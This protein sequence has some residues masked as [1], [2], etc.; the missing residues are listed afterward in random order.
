MSGHDVGLADAVP[1]ERSIEDGLHEVAI[2]QVIGPLAL[3]L[4]TRGN[5][6][7]AQSLFSVTELLQPGIAH[8]QIPGDQGHLD[9]DLPIPI[10]FR[11][12]ALDLHG[13]VVFAFRAILFHPSQRPLE[14]L[15]IVDTPLHAAY[16]LGHVD[17][18]NTHA[19]VRLKHSLVHDGASDPHGHTAHGQVGFA[20]HS[21]HRQAGFGKLQQ[22][23][24]NIPRDGRIAR[25]LDIPAVDAESR[26][27]LLGV[28]GHHSRQIDRA[29]A[30]GAVEAPDCLGNE[31]VHVHRLGPV[32]PTGG[33][34]DGNADTLLRKFVSALSRLRDAADASIGDDALYRQT[35][36]MAQVFAQQIRN[37][38]G[39]CH[40]LV[41]QGLSH[42]LPA[43]V[44]RRPNADLRHVSDEPVV[45]RNRLYSGY[46]C[47]FPLLIRSVSVEID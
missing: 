38:L 24:S 13:I 35:V 34:S 18:F 22:L 25:I 4:E 12:A 8:H 15:R 30:L 44:N 29:R 46:I 6:V 42:S 9:G 28:P 41:L 45:W 47:H 16:E 32:A 40:R 43:T 26:Q 20:A 14:L 33:D 2:G 7:V 39:H 3:P 37:C 11:P 10:L 21:G 17:G 5:R 19:Q 23:L 27:P 31:W 36:G 1:V